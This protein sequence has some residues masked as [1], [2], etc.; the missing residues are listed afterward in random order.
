MPPKQEEP[1]QLAAAYM[2][3]PQQPARAEEPWQP[4]PWQAEAAFAVLPWQ[5]EPR[6]ELPWQELLSRRK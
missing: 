4:L 6:Q 1:K 5:E 2:F 3:P